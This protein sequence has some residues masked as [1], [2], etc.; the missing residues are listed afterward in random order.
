MVVQAQT[1]PPPAARRRGNRGLVLAS[2]AGVFVLGGIIAF[3]VTRPGDDK[4]ETRAASPETPAPVA[5]AD[6]ATS[7]VIAPP[8]HPVVPPADP[9]AD[10][11]KRMLTVIAGFLKWSSAHKGAPCPSAKDLGVNVADSWGHPMSITC[12]DQPANQTIGIVSSGPDGVA[13]SRDDIASWTMPTDVTD[14]IAGSRW[15]AK[16]PGGPRPG[17]TTRPGSTASP[18]GTVGSGAMK[19]G[20]VGDVDGDG[21]PDRRGP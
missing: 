10:M 17:G 7:V 19:S 16:K 21:I 6:A 2:A 20:I 15:V 8:E 11:T 13:G 3:G 9:R 12:T 4:P 14:V 1:P 18:G 5:P